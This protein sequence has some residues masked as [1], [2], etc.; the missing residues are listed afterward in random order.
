MT[1]KANLERKIEESD[2][3]ELYNEINSL[4]IQEWIEKESILGY[5]G[6]KVDNLVTRIAHLEHSMEFL[7]NYI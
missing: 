6:R 7:W 5:Y 2:R 3:N 4:K 1:D